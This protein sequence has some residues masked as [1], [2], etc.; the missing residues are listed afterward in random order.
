MSAAQ[1][2]IRFFLGS[3]TAEG[4]HSS[5]GDLYRPSDRVYLLKGGPG[6]GKSTLLCRLYDALADEDTEVF[7]CSADPASLDA[8]RFPSRGL[9]VLDATAPHAVEPAYWNA[10]EQPIPLSDCTRF[11]LLHTHREQII[12]LTDQ[13]RG[14]HA[15]CRRY[16]QGAASLLS[17]AKRLQLAALDTEKIKRLARRL[18]ENEWRG[19]RS[20]QP[21]VVQQRFLSA[22]TPDGITV[23]YETLQALCPRIYT[24]EDEY[25]G[26]AS[27]LLSEL[28][29]YAA[30]DGLRCLS[31]PDPLFPTEG[32]AHLLFPEIGLG[33]TVSN[34]FHAVDFP[35][36]RRIHASRFLAPDALRPHRAR[37]QFLRRGAA[38]LL[39]EA[40]S[41]CARAKAAHDELEAYYVAACDRE[42]LQQLTDRVLAAL[43]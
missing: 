40:T 20:E 7:C 16:M 24:V 34:R 14:L 17:D 23:L 37:L 25:G 2:P 1:A 4:F 30:A 26:A 27:L 35:T 5:V 42:Q 3:N 43:T 36:F 28:C 11:D 10:V 19:W 41:L 22:M 38:E 32:P 12:A 9:C 33:F 21:G 15:R 6:S 29:R 8:L 39:G 18:A 31:C 13:A